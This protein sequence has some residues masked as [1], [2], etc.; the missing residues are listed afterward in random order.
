M[1]IEKNKLV[2]GGVIAVV[3]IFLISY[4]FIALGDD[5]DDTENLKQTLVP[6]LEQEQEDYTSKLDAINDLKEVR[7]TNAPSI[8]DESLLDSLGYYDP[9][10]AIKEKER[11]VD[12]IYRL[13]KIDYKENRYRDAAPKI[14]VK[15]I[16]PK[17]DSIVTEV[18]PTIEAKELGLEHQLFF[19]SNP[20]KNE[21]SANVKTDNQI[22]VAVDGNQTVK[23]DFR[24]R[25]RLDKDAII[26][27]R[28]IPKNT[29]VF[30]FI[31]FQPNRV[32]IEI[33]NIQNTSVHLT[34]F[35]YE[36]G[37]EGI[38]VENSFRA[39]ARREIVEDVVNDINIG[40][41]PQVS[42]IKQLFQRSNRNV[43]ATIVNNYKLILKQE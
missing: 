30:G 41:V 17:K 5:E 35:D 3:V 2:F 10:N 15:P 37:S 18:D 24:L 40:G 7:E 16:P 13:G 12:S 20:L 14:K 42:G 23:A 8:Y 28:L 31:S 6:E 19:A 34:A 43:K 33:E 25:M 22:Y 26:N 11:I 27:N 29:P 39:D 4:S 9:E 38:Y 32:L 21:L 1:K 36:D